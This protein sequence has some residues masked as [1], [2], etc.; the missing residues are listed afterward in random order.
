MSRV[1]VDAVIGSAF[2]ATFLPGMHLLHPA[3]SN[4]A[5]VKASINTLTSQGQT[6][7]LVVRDSVQ[8]HN[9][10]GVLP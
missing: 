10:Q 5:A 8:T 9:E 4:D 7:L 6:A 1:E 2:F 3:S